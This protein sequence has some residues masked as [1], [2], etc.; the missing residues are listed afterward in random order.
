M[1]TRTLKLTTLADNLVYKAGLHGQWGLS[2]LLELEDSKGNMRKILLDTGNDKAPLFHNIKKLKINL[3][4]LDAVVLSHGHDDHTV[5]TVELIKDSGGCPVYAHPHCF[6]PRFELS[7]K[8]ERTR[9][10]VPEG[11]GIAEIEAVGGTIKL[12]TKPTEVVPGLWTTGQ[13]PRESFE[14]I[15]KS[16]EGTRMTVEIDGM[17]TED[18]IFCDMALWTEVKDQGPW[19]LTG[20]AHSGSINTLKQVK[21]L[22]NSK[23]LHAL[24][25]G[26]HLVGRDEKYIHNTSSQLSGFNLKL[27]SPC[28]CTGFNAMAKLMDD[29]RNIFVLNYCGRVIS[30]LEWPQDAIL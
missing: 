2:I 10:G 25:G 11:Q 23:R 15:P 24:I 6:L 8:G 20:C 12:S 14:N 29:F 7:K 13:V 27:L 1:T 26:T 22:S 17:E 4:D 30:S 18:Q 3:K 9:I 16:P 28:H 21:K 5:A 19:V